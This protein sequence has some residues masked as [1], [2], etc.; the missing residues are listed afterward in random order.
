[1]N[2]NKG[3][4]KVVAVVAAVVLTGAVLVGWAGERRASVS[5][6]PL[7]C[8]ELDGQV[9]CVDGDLSQQMSC[10]RLD[11]NTVLCAA[12]SGASL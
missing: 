2:R 7:A 9:V 6:E 4:L 8:Y 1:M 11:A 3:I 12:D 10:E 5:S